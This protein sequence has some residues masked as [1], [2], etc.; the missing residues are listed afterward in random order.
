MLLL[1]YGDYQGQYSDEQNQSDSNHDDNGHYYEEDEVNDEGQ[2]S[3][4]YGRIIRNR[5]N[6]NSNKR[7]YSKRIVQTNSRRGNLFRSSLN[8]RQS[9]IAKWTAPRNKLL[10][11]KSAR[12]WNNRRN[13]GRR[14][15]DVQYAGNAAQFK[16]LPDL[17]V[18]VSGAATIYNTV[19]SPLPKNGTNPPSGL[20]QAV[21][22]LQMYATIRNFAISFS[23][24]R[25]GIENNLNQVLTNT[26]ALGLNK[27]EMLAFYGYLDLYNSLKLSTQAFTAPFIAQDQTFNAI[28]LNFTSSLKAIVQDVNFLLD[29][30]NQIT[31]A[32]AALTNPDPTIANPTMK[33][34][35]Q[36]DATLLLLP[37]LLTIYVNIQNSITD[38]QFN[39]N[40]LQNI[41]TQI[42][43]VISNL[44]LIVNGKADQVVTGGVDKV[45]AASIIALLYTMLG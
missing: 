44:Q 9:T 15:L 31:K 41:R 12:S 7:L 6:A 39:L 27:N 43:T 45:L 14:W 24:N 4:N 36:I 25:A 17:L 2:G 28:L 42:Q 37:N 20:Q 35:A 40:N 38:L 32:T 16:N 23:S 3:H 18:L 34:L 30:N 11:F 22:Y 29:Q 21:Y 8:R 1:D 10:D 19:F 5:R 26:T 33:D 13:S